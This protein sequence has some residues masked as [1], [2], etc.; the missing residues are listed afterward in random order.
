MNQKTV[1]TSIAD[2]ADR[3]VVDRQGD[4]VGTVLDVYVDEQTGR[5]EW[6]AISTGLF[7]SK[8]SFAPIA[9]AGFDTSGQVV[10]PFDKAKVK[11]APRA[12]ADG[13]L[14]A[15][16][17]QQLYT[18]YGM[19]Y[20]PPTGQL[21]PPDV[22]QVPTTGDRTASMVRSEEEL[23]IDKHRQE[24]GR[25]K[26]RKWVETENVHVTVPV[27]R[28]MARVVRESVTDGDTT[29]MSAFEAGEEEVV[30]SE[31]VV[32]VQKRT[33]AKERVGLQTESVT[34]QVPVDEVVRKERVEVEGGQ[35]IGDE[36]TRS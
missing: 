9:G 21:P 19:A 6:L 2:F 22:A 28:Q 24:S 11:D 27:E 13:H 18:Y 16:E 3:T 25:V 34:E 36:T 26:L 32:D 17:E 4:K 33:V 14:S 8:V 20:T 7:G 5:P 35:L 12:E 10:V 31:E 30:L 23:T 15:Q 29:G 1:E